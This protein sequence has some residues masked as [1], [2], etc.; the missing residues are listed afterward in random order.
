MRRD[1]RLESKRTAVERDYKVIKKKDW[2]IWITF[3]GYPLK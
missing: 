3:D 1:I 2:T